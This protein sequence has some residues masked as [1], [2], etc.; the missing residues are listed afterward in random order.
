MIERKKYANAY[1]SEPNYSVMIIVI[2]SNKF[3]VY[4]RHVLYYYL[5][6]NYF[7]LFFDLIKNSKSTREVR[8]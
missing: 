4:Y 1:K 3:R 7:R 6:N 2:I 5:F 8:T